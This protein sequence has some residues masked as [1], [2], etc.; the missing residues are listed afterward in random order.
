MRVG[1]FLANG[2]ICRLSEGAMRRH[3]LG[4]DPRLAR[5]W[6]QIQASVNSLIEIATMGVMRAALPCMCHGCD[7]CGAAMHVSW[8][9]LH[10]L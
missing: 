7:A 2:L 6:D 5:P 1:N 9:E 4:S 8:V 3:D 10:G